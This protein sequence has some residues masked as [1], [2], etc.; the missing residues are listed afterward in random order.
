MIRRASVVFLCMVLLVSLVMGA[1]GTKESDEDAVAGSAS[2]IDDTFVVVT[3]NGEP[4]Y[5]KEYFEQFSQLS[6]QYGISAD[7]ENSEQVKTMVLES[8]VNEKIIEQSLSQE[9]LSALKEQQMILAEEGLKQDIDMYIETIAMPDILAELGEDYTQEEFESVR[10]KYEDEVIE[11]SGYT[12]EKL[13]EMYIPGL[14]ET[15]PPKMILDKYVPTDEQV[16]ERYDQ[17]VADD[18]K[19]MD[20]SPSEYESAV[21]YDYPIFYVPEGARSV[22]HILVKI[23]DEMMGAI[24]ALEESG[25]SKAKELL[26]ESALADIKD[27]AQEISDKISTGELSFEEAIE[28]YIEDAEAEGQPAVI[29]EEIPIVVTQTAQDILGQLGSEEIDFKEASKLYSEEGESSLA[30]EF[31]LGAM[32]L[33]AT[34]DVS[35]LIGTVFGYHIIEYYSEVTSGPV[36]YESV[37]DEIFQFLQQEGW[38]GSIDEWTATAVVEYAEF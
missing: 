5:Y 3:V 31:A 16:R 28:V 20:E 21:M 23:D 2:D 19:I 1:C 27:F 18:K 30:S 22:R 15:E 32:M 6:E 8:L 12:R 26:L 14:T 36:E 29:T 37:K 9:E 10:Q 13:V 17:E 25:Y 4:I 33:S 7:D 34:G 11:G 38:R 24:S 35:D